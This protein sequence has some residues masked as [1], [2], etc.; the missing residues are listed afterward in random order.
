VEELA[1]IENSRSEYR[2]IEDYYEAINHQNQIIA[3]LLKQYKI[4]EN[5]RNEYF[6]KFKLLCKIAAPFT[7]QSRKNFTT[8]K[9]YHEFNEF[10]QS[11]Y[12]EFVKSNSNG[13]IP[14]QL[15]IVTMRRDGNPY[16]FDDI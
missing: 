9:N 2:S 4:E 11:K 7:G 10:I 12:N 6:K 15:R 14:D 3:K 13:R 5:E 8:D 16:M 1:R